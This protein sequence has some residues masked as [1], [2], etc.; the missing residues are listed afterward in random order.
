MDAEFLNEVTKILTAFA[1]TKLSAQ[2]LEMTGPTKEGLN[3]RWCLMSTRYREVT[4]LLVTKKHFFGKPT[5]EHFE[6]HGLG[7]TRQLQP[8]LADLQTFLAGSE[9]ELTG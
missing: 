8:N 9:M 1:Q 7:Q 5:P 4:I 6:V 2:L 3:Y